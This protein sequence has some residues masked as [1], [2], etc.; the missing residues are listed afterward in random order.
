MNIAIDGA[1]GTLWPEGPAWDGAP[2]AAIG[3]LAFDTPEAGARWLARAEAELAA[4]GCRAILAPM[5]GDTWHS[6]RAWIESDGSPPFALEPV[7]G[8]HDLAALQA[9]GFVPLEHYASSRAPVPPPGLPRPDVPGIRVTAWD[10][11][12]A[13]TLLTQL[14]ALAGS[15]FADK[16]FFKPLDRDGFLA[17]YRPLLTHIDPRMVLFAHDEGGQLAGFLFGLP[18]FLQGPA[19]TQA[20]LK[21]YASMRKGVGRLLAWHFDELARELGCSH[22]VHALMHSA[23]ISLD[24]SRMH[25]GTVFRRYA[26]F[27]KRLG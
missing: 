19:P 17:L 22:V 26:L 21:T 15:S 7:S 10:G 5:D 11:K 9:A 27:G 4:L 14:H 6:Y 23:N 8:A 25:E 24:R 20:I 13:E 1:A 2:A 12:G 16:L 3:R 18:D